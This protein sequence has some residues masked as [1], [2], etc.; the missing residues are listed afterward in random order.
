MIEEEDTASQATFAQGYQD[1]IKEKENKENSQNL[2]K[3]KR[4][5]IAEA[6]GMD[7]PKKERQ[8]V[9]EVLS[10][11]EVPTVMHL[12][13]NQSMFTTQQIVRRAQH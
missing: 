12:E 1:F 5:L 10:T 13:G 4:N 2:L 9:S 7:K 6:V 3:V 11:C 8:F